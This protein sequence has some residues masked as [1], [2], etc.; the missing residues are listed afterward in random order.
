MKKEFILSGL[1]LLALILPMCAFAQKDPTIDAAM[2]MT[3]G[4]RFLDA[5]YK[6]TKLLS[7]LI[8]NG[9][10]VAADPSKHKV[11]FEIINFGNNGNTVILTLELGQDGIDAGIG[12]TTTYS[13]SGQNLHVVPGYGGGAGMLAV[14]RGSKDCGALIGSGGKWVASVNSGSNTYTIN[15]FKKGMTRAEVESVVGQLGMSQFKF[16]RNS[17]N[18]KVYSLFWLDMKKQYNFFGTDYKYQMRNDKKYGDFY[19]DA[20]GK[21][22]KWLLFM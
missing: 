6:I 12:S 18:L 7:G 2:K 19:F 22:V 4:G 14:L 16:T 20:Q 10:G 21:L 13:W 11:T 1:V 15:D 9:S 5:N 17:G 3:K 8:A